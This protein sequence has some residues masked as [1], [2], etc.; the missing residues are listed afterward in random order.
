MIREFVEI[1]I[2]SCVKLVGICLSHEFEVDA[3]KDFVDGLTCP[4]SEYVTCKRIVWEENGII[5]GV[6]G[7]YRTDQHPLDH[8]GICWFG[9]HPKHRR[10]GIGSALINWCLQEA[11]KQKFTTLFVWSVESARS[12]YERFGFKAVDA[13]LKPKESDISMIKNLEQL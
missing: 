2:P 4:N 3:A 6:C 8:A 13:Y 5:I 9:V 12:F 1:D 7:I 11:V 10:N